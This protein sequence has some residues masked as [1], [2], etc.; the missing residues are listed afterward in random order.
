MNYTWTT[1]QWYMMGLS[2]LLILG[3]LGTEVFL[4]KFDVLHVIYN[5]MLREKE[6]KLICFNKFD[7]TNNERVVSSLYMMTRLTLILI[8]SYIWQFCVIESYTLTDQG[9]PDEFCYSGSGFHCFQTPLS[10]G[11]FAEAGDMVPIDCAA[12]PSGFAPIAGK[13]AISC[14]R[15]RDQNAAIWMQ[16][17]AISNAL[18]LL[19]TRLF[20]V[21][22]WVS[23]Q[24]ISCMIG[25]SIAAVVIIIAIIVTAI[26]G[27]FSSLVNSWLGYVALSI[28][29][30]IIYLA[31]SVAIEIRRMKR[32][33]LAR[34]QNQTL[35]DFAKIAQEFQRTVS[36]DDPSTGMQ[37]AQSSSALD[38][39]GLRLRS[40]Q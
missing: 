19:M 29:P 14:Y 32:N 12:G 38:G 2:I 28:L 21:L 8:F 5:Q 17:L 35:N 30:Y 20:E 10:W 31:R 40:K 23:L 18:G 39:S 24:S 7:V 4:R 11:S 37:T 26:S 1:Y 33:E 13:V 15:L 27:T 22:I 6:M 25:L 9:F 36:A 3:L 16:S 34:I